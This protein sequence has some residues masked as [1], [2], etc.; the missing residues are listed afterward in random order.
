MGYFDTLPIFTHLYPTVVWRHVETENQFLTAGL[1]GDQCMSC[2]ASK[3]AELST[4]FRRLHNRC[5]LEALTS[6]HQLSSVV[7]FQDESIFG[8]LGAGDLGLEDH[9][10]KILKITVFWRILATAQALH[11]KGFK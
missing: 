7:Q 4:P 10:L 1:F 9:P 8:H 6:C 5:M 2:L 3:I 11:A